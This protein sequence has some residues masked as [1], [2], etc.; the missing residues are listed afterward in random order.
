[1]ESTVRT[2]GIWVEPVAGGVYLP[3]LLL[4]DGKKSHCTNLGV[5]LQS[6]RKSKSC[7][8]GCLQNPQTQACSRVAHQSPVGLQSA[9]LCRA[10][11]GDISDCSLSSWGLPLGPGFSLSSFPSLVLLATPS[12]SP[13]SALPPPTLP[14]PRMQDSGL[15][16]WM[17]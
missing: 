11:L 6:S 4:L 7:S 3:P 14:L 17:R 1:M 15:G 5:I 8:M 10:V 16:G 12:P 9:A 2:S 13:S